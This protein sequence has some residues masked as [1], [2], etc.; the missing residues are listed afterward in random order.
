MY[1]EFMKKKE[2]EPLITQND[3]EVFVC[4]KGCYN[5]AKKRLSSKSSYYNWKNDSPRGEDD[6]VGSLEGILMKWMMEEGNYRKY[7]GYKHGGKSKNQ[8]HKEL[9]TLMNESNVLVK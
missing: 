5:K 7:H 6:L 9:S 4:K 1:D 2:L 3:V 8:Y